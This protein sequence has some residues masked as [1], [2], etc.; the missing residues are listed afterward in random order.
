MEPIYERVHRCFLSDQ[1]IS[2]VKFNADLYKDF[3]KDYNI[4]GFPTL[5]L[6][7][8]GSSGKTILDYNGPNTESA[9]ISFINENTGTFRVPGGDLNTM[10]NHYIHFQGICL[11][12]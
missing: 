9:I 3:A 11:L 6:F 4:E 12:N 10:V 5:K 8:K 2:I 7:L 1:H